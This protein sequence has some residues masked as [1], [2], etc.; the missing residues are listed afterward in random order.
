M[1][2]I[3]PSSLLRNGFGRCLW[4][5]WFFKWC[6]WACPTLVA[7]PSLNRR[8][9]RASRTRSATSRC[10]SEIPFDFLPFNSC[11]PS[12]IVF[13]YKE[14]FSGFPFFYAIDFVRLYC[15][16]LD[17]P[18]RSF[19]VY[20]VLPNFQQARVAFETIPPYS[21]RTSYRF[22]ILLI[23]IFI[24]CN[25]VAFR[26]FQSILTIGV[27]GHFFFSTGKGSADGR[28]AHDTGRRVSGRPTRRHH[29]RQDVAHGLAL[30]PGPRHRCLPGLS[31]G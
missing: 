27:C 22:Q 1:I 11:L 21:I 12:F 7:S 23:H 3:L 24:D 25:R 26:V 8:P 6:R 29:H 14:S 9:S 10:P 17:F 18:L 16:L 28:R 19:L 20:L 13:F 30:P 4:T 15:V 5:R 2:V 31:I